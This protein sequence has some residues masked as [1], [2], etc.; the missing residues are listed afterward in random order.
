MLIFTL[1]KRFILISLS[2]FFLITSIH[3]TLYKCMWYLPLV[4]S[5]H[6]VDGRGICGLEALSSV[7]SA[8]SSSSV[9][10]E[11]EMKSF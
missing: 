7:E 1:T 2:I 10:S 3:G 5:G 6:E 11:I 4:V 8:T 9:A